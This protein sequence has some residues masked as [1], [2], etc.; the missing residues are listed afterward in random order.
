M[1]PLINIVIPNALLPKF[2]EL[3][4]FKISLGQTLTEGNADNRT[5][6]KTD[7][8]AY[9]YITHYN[10][11]V[12]KSGEIGEIKVYTDYSMPTMKWVIFINEQDYEL[13]W[14]KS[15]VDGVGL[16]SYINSELSNILNLNKAVGVPKE[17]PIEPSETIYVE[18]EGNADMVLKN[19]GQASYADVRAYLKKK[20]MEQ[21]G[22]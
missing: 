19:P 11:P 4:V 3:S 18:V 9:A 6:T 13:E 14:N 15:K 2:R 5:L 12:F 22:L 17:A 20:R 21:L 8:F 16:Y 10:R 7:T 1:K